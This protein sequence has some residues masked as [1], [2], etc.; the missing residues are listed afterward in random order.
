MQ[1]AVAAWAVDPGPAWWDPV[2]ES[3]LQQLC[4]SIFLPYGPERF[5]EFLASQAAFRSVG[6][7]G[8]LA[9]LYA[10]VLELLEFAG[11]ATTRQ[12]LQEGA[13]I[14]ISPN[15]SNAAR[16]RLGVLDQLVGDHVAAIRELSQAIAYRKAVGDSSHGAELR[17]LAVSQCE[18]GR[19]DLAAELVQ[20]AFDVAGAGRSERETQR[21][22][23]VA[24]HVLE[25][26]GQAELAAAALGKA[27]PY[28]DNYIDTLGTVA[29]RLQSRMGER[30]ADAVMTAGAA[31]NLA[32]LVHEVRNALVSIAP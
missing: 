28:Q 2:W 9:I 19:A 18:I 23:A 22:L 12:L 26:V 13:S 4:C 14:D 8:W 5:D 11:V 7:R 16:Y 24:A 15:W 3:G 25:A 30:R 1:R 17:F 20:S 6:D 21:T 10:Q 29:S 32:E 31:R 27:A